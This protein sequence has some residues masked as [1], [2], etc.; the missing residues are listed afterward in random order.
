[1]DIA[2]LKRKIRKLYRNLH[3]ADDTT[4]QII[5]ITWFAQTQNLNTIIESVKSNLKSAADV[6][7]TLNITVP[8]ATK[9]DQL[10]NTQNPKTIM[11]DVSKEND[12]LLFT[13]WYNELS[14]SF[15][16]IKLVKEINYRLRSISS[17]PQTNFQF[18]DAIENPYDCESGLKDLINLINAS[19]SKIMDILIGD[20][21]GSVNVRP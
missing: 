16:L 14:L 15:T 10:F 17:N 7:R 9:I 11:S 20:K 19:I 6:L 5:K 13:G 4:K 21:Q 1:M 8:N 2:E 12:S 18:E 3:N